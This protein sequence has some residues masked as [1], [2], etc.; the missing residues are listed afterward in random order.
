MKWCLLIK[1]RIK[2]I[3]G[4]K[5]YFITESGRVFT[6][7][8]RGKQ[9]KYRLR[10]LKPKYPGDKYPQKYLN[11][12]LINN[13]GYK[14]EMIHRLVAKYFVPGYFEGA[15]VNHKDGNNK[16]NHASNLEWV[17]Q[18]E[19]IHQSY[20]DSGLD[21]TRNYKIWDLYNINNKFIGSFIGHNKLSDYVS[22]Y[23]PDI[24]TSMLTKH[25]KHKYLYIVKH[26][27]VAKG[28]KL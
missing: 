22:K 15:V 3:D 13:E 7:R 24:S 4:Y 21:Q 9:S 10:E 8:L 11:I 19:N 12:C 25:G 2:R 23:Y 26:E 27:P 18:K 1:E 28:L 17:T 16:N 5:D 6:Q 20:K 14:Y